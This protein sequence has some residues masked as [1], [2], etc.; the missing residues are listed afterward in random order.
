MKFGNYL[1]NYHPDCLCNPC[2][3]LFSFLQCAFISGLGFRAGSYKCV[4]KP[5]YY[6]PNVTAREKYF[7]GSVIE[8]E[9]ADQRASYYSKPDSFQCLKC[10]PGCKTCED[11][12]P[13]IVILNW[14]VRKALMGLT[15]VS[16][17]AAI[18]IMAF[19]VHFREFKVRTRF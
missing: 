16:I 1:W 18:G 11:N 19:V 9:A 7:N 2:P 8:V 14:P 12:S 17:I 13:C 4:C 6:F 5:G 15:A 10:Q 3:F